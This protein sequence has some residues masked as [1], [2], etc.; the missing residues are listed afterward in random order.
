MSSTATPA[1]PTWPTQLLYDSS[2]GRLDVVVDVS[3]ASLDELTVAVGSSTILLRFDGRDG[4][5]D[6]LRLSPPGPSHRFDDDHRAVYNNGV[7]SVSV[8]TASRIEA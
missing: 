6:E 7:L 5:T 3:P 2:S 4:Y 8:G 1:T